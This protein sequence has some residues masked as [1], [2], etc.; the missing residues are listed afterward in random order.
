VPISIHAQKADRG[1]THFPRC[2]FTIPF[3]RGIL[4]YRINSE[5]LDRVIYNIEA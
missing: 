2:I 5:F 4:A 3:L 1:P